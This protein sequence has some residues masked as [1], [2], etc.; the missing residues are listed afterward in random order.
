MLRCGMRESRVEACP[1][2]LGSIDRPGYMIRKKLFSLPEA[3]ALKGRLLFPSE[4]SV[5]FCLNREEGRA[6]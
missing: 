6:A 4:L 2:P 3:V 5:R 1:S